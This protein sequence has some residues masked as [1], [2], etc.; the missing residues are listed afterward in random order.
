[1]SPEKS[2]VVRP[3]NNTIQELHPEAKQ[4]VLS[5]LSTI[6][7]QMELFHEHHAQ[8]PFLRDSH[9]QLVRLSYSTKIMQSEIGNTGCVERYIEGTIT[10]ALIKYRDLDQGHEKLRLEIGDFVKHGVHALAELN[11]SQ[12]TVYNAAMER[13]INLS[14][15]VIPRS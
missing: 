13:I 9:T 14:S 15:A 2:P 3:A 11:P 6:T 4:R 7:Q 8:H 5:Y 12:A 10:D 1:M